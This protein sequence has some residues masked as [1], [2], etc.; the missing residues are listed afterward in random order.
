MQC[1]NDSGH[2]DGTDGKQWRDHVGVVVHLARSTAVLSGISRTDRAWAPDDV[3][4][5]E[6]HWA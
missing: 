4:Q 1:F 2:K 6:R 3:D 5:A